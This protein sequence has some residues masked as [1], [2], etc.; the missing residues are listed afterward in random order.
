MLAA[1]AILLGIATPTISH[2][3][4]AAATT[5][6]EICTKMGDLAEWAAQQ[7]DAVVSFRQTVRA[8]NHDLAR[9][10]RADPPPTSDLGKYI[11]DYSDR[12]I[13]DAWL[14][15][16]WQAMDLKKRVIGDCHVVFDAPLP[17]RSARN[18][19]DPN[20][21]YDAPAPEPKTAE[22]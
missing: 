12:V 14:L 11:R 8:Y 22:E 6:T 2:A 4:D 1:G 20:P 10:M 5:T 17:F 13:H 21:D 3:D 7:R 19:D 18:P 16:N 15:P 9:R